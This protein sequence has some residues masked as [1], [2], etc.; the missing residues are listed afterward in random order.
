MTNTHIDNY[1]KWKT[2]IS[3]SIYHCYLWLSYYFQSVEDVN[4]SPRKRSNLSDGLLVRS[5]DSSENEWIYS[6]NTSGRVVIAS[7]H[8]EAG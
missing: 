4:G 1:V 2:R 3:G 6:P 7:Y 8:N 5:N